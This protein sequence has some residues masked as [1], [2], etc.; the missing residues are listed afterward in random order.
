M[1]NKLLTLKQILLVI[2]G[3]GLIGI[4]IVGIYPGSGFLGLG[5]FIWCEIIALRK[6]INKNK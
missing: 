6:D 4:G 1:K 5:C 3:L 2:I